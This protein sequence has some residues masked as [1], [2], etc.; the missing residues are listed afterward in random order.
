[1]FGKMV[2]GGDMW[3]S[4]KLNSDS[5]RAMENELILADIAKR[6]N[7]SNEISGL[8]WLI[9]V[10]TGGIAVGATSM[11]QKVMK[12]RDSANYKEPAKDGSGA[13]LTPSRGHSEFVRS[14]G[15]FQSRT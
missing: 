9:K 4:V 8:S 3:Q 5:S 1:M 2:Q 13:N 7:L 10:A 14:I 15:V 11:K 6:E 12:A